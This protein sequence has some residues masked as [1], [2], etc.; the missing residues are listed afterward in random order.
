M[1]EV[2]LFYAPDLLQCEELPS[3][4]AAHAIRVLRMQEGN[5]ILVTDGRGYLYECIITLASPKHC[6]V[7]I[8][9][10]TLI[11]KFWKGNIHLAVAPTKNMDRMEWLTEK[12]TEIGVDSF[13]FLNCQ[14]S[15]RH[16]VKTERVE[17]IVVAATKQSHKT[18]KPQVNEIV[19]FKKYISQI[20]TGQKFIAHCHKDGLPFLG[21][22]VSSDDDTFI[23]IG[24]EGDFSLEEVELAE[25]AGF[26]SVSLGKSR[27]RTETAALVAVHL[28][29]LSKRI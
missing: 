10:R 8:N 18:T 19:P 5:E 20:T 3:E 24:P 4:E 7:Q 12:A 9:Q 27:L 1:K 22:L 28:A 13:S 17:K 21:D 29:H 11:D 14:N 15:E 26:C 16:V 6:K 25:K 2:H 23:L